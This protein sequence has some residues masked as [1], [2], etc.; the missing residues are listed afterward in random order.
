MTNNRKT[1]GFVPGT[2]VIFDDG[3]IAPGGVCKAVF[4]QVD[5][6]TPALEPGRLYTLE[7]LCGPEFWGGLS[8]AERQMAGRIMVRLVLGGWLPLRLVGCRHRNPK[9]YEPI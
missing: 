2:L 7:L 8:A 5:E 1:G 4:Q 9:Q 3:Y 6:V